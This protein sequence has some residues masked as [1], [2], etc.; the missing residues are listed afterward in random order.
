MT[1]R[2]ACGRNCGCGEPC[3]SA[4]TQAEAEHEGAYES[5]RSMDRLADGAAADMVFGREP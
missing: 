4:E 1:G 2:R 3:A 5:Q